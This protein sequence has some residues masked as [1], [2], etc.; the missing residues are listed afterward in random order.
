MRPLM[1][2]LPLVVGCAAA[3]TVAKPAVPLI[4][5]GCIPAGWEHPPEKVGEA[6]GR[7]PQ[8]PASVLLPFD[9]SGAEGSGLRS[10]L[11]P[12]HACR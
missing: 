6:P 3:P 5:P 11:A 9:G 12:P 7:A 1:L 10:E 2:L 4:A 8:A